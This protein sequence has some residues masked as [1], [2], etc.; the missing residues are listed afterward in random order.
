[1]ELCHDNGFPLK[2]QPLLV[3]CIRKDINAAYIQVALNRTL[4]I[5]TFYSVTKMCQLA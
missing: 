2:E 1:M 3:V 5:I 4:H